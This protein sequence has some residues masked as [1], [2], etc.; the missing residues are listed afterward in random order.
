VSEKNASS[1][2]LRGLKWQDEKA[3]MKKLA[4]SQPRNARDEIAVGHAVRTRHPRQ[5][6][7]N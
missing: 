3:L 2:K 1:M 4:A 5:T 7:A 6:G